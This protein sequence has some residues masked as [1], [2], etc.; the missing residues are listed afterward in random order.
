MHRLHLW[1]YLYLQITNNNMFPYYFGDKAT[2]IGRGGHCCNTLEMIGH[3]EGDGGKMSWFNV[4]V[5]VG[6]GIGLGMCLSVGIGIGLFVWTCQTT[7]KT[8][9]KGFLK[10]FL[11][12]TSLTWVMQ[13]LNIFPS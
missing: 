6:V 1:S 9:R 11:K 7:A 10:T 2:T 5:R 13:Q 12:S 8:F 4:G 3:L